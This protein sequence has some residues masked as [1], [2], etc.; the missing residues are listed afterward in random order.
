MPDWL[1]KEG[2]DKGDI[3][4]TVHE[5]LLSFSGVFQLASLAVLTQIFVNIGKR[6]GKDHTSYVLGYVKDHILRDIKG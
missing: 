4:E 1:D 6:F 2:T 5:G 3:T